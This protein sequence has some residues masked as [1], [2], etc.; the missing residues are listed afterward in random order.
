MSVFRG[1]WDRRPML[2]SFDPGYGRSVAAH[3]GTLTAGHLGPVYT[4]V[5]SFAISS[6][7][8]LSTL[9]LAT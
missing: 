2:T 9:L 1:I 4:P 8:I 7:S 6:W 3:R 5:S